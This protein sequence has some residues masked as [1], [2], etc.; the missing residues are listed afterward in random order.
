MNQLEQLFIRMVFNIIARN[1][2]DHVKNIAF[3]MNRNG[4]WRL[5]SHTLFLQYKTGMTDKYSG[6]EKLPW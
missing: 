1:H 4:I 2:D 6:W 3:L 5:F